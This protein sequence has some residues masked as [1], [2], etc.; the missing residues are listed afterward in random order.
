MYSQHASIN[1]SWRQVSMVALLMM[2]TTESHSC[3]LMLMHHSNVGTAN[4]NAF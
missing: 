4:G 3:M 2:L 1:I